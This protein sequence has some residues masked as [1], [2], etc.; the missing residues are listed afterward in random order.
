VLPPRV[1]VPMHNDAQ[2]RRRTL[3]GGPVARGAAHG[4]DAAGMQHGPYLPEHRH[5]SHV[6]RVWMVCQLTGMQGCMPQWPAKQ[7]AAWQ[8]G[9]AQSSSCQ[10][11]LVAC[12]QTAAANSTAAADICLPP[13][14]PLLKGPRQQSAMQTT[15]CMF[16]NGNGD[17]QHQAAVV[18]FCLLQTL[19]CLQMRLQ[20]NLYAAPCCC[21]STTRLLSHDAVLN[22][23]RMFVCCDAGPDPVGLSVGLCCHPA[24]WRQPC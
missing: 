19:H 3:Q 4:G 22:S 16:D 23:R 5:P 13:P 20:H 1:P 10:Q 2:C 8:Q 12:S 18:H 17:H 15:F 14:G 6:P 9:S 21:S 24:A 7:Q 11:S